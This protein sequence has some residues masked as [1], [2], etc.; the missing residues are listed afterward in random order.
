ML[1]P[2]VLALKLSRLSRPLNY[3]VK[4]ILIAV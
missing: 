1:Q 2:D 3:P 4:P